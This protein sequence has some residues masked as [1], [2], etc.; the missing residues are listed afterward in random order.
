MSALR[1]AAAGHGEDGGV[2]CPRCPENHTPHDMRVDYVF[3]NAGLAD[4]IRDARI[5]NETEGSDHQPVWLEIDLSGLA[6]RVSTGHTPQNFP[7]S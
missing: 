6:R 5:D 3:V 7:P 1:W 2:T 4:R